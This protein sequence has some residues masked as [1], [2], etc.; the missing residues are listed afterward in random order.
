M[1]I[2][3]I[4]VGYQCPRLNE[5]L[6]PWVSLKCGIYDEKGLEVV[7]KSKHDF[8]IS[9][10]AA[11]FKERRD[12]GE[13]YSNQRNED[14]LSSY[15]ASGAIDAFAIERD[16]GILDFEARNLA[17]QAAKKIKMPE[18]TLVWQL[19]L[20][21]EFY[22]MS[23]ITRILDYIEENRY[24]DWYAINFKNYINTTQ[25]YVK[26]FCPPRINWYSRHGGIEKWCWDNDVVYKN[27]C[28]TSVASRQV[29]PP[30]VAF[31]RH[32][33]WC[34]PKDYLKKKVAYQHRAIGCCS[35][36][37]SDEKD[38]LEHDSEY[39]A[40]IKQPIPEIFQDV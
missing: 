9:C 1:N 5:V 12:M 3:V 27:G 13:V 39:F 15:L 25:T 19:D 17:W 11:L 7:P 35:Y 6:A 30:S 14:I 28:K 37:W 18:P 20:G 16:A 24:A 38:C 22:S 32:E 26:G 29:I 23:E 34:G 36:R 10:T 40:A 2:L 21:D 33:S 8:V 31:V 4:A